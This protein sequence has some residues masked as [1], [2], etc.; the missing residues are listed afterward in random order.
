MASYDATMPHA[1]FRTATGPRMMI[2][3]SSLSKVPAYSALAPE[4]APTKVK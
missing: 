1:S 2:S 4:H 3:L